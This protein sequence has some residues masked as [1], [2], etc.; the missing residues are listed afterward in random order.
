MVLPSRDS[1]SHGRG[2]GRQVILFWRKEIR[3]VR[4]RNEV[5]W[6]KNGLRSRD[7]IY[8]TEAYGEKRMKTSYLNF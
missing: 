7:S 2:W 5:K 4:A 6:G 3:N 1:W 8:T